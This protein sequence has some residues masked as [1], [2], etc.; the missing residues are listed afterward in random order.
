MNMAMGTNMVKDS[1]FNNSVMHIRVTL[2]MLAT[3]KN[4]EVGNCKHVCCCELGKSDDDNHRHQHMT[5][6]IAMD[7][8]ITA[9]T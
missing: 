2:V 9:R 1:N 3:G 6:N 8:G 5:I 4:D 7:S